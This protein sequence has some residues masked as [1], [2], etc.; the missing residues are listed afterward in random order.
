M[1]IK[2]TDVAENDFA[3]LHWNT[4]VI[5][6]SVHDGA[7]HEQDVCWQDVLEKTV[8]KEAIFKP[9]ISHLHANKPVLTI[10]TNE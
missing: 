8:F 10:H 9:D 7:V 1:T 6:K 4:C 2:S 5:E 3:A